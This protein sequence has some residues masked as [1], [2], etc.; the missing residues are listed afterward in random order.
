M[1]VIF[2]A[3]AGGS[4]A[5]AGATL[6]TTL[7]HAAIVIPRQVRTEPFRLNRKFMEFNTGFLATEGILTHE[8]SGKPAF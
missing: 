3:T 4:D 7:L 6:A 8:A 1:G 5:V 2:A